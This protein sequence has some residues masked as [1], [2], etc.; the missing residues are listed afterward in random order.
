MCA[1]DVTL[2]SQSAIVWS[3]RLD[4]FQHRVSIF[5]GKTGNRLC[6]VTALAAYLATR[7]NQTGAFLPVQRESP[8]VT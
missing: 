5:L 4:P 8:T 6:P 7:G 3:G 1:G 2:D